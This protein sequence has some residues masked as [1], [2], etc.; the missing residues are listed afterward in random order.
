MEIVRVYW[1]QALIQSENLAR[2]VDMSDGINVLN[3]IDDVFVD[4]R[5]VGSGHRRNIPDRISFRTLLETLDE[6]WHVGA[7]SAP[8]EPEEPSLGGNWEK[9]ANM[10]AASPA[11]ASRLL[12]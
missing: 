9:L 5:F 8:S 3:A 6:L 12:P 4:K 1:G 7:G 2:P 11:V 10:R